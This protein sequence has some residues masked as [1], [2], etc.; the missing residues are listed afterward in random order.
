MD[1]FKELAEKAEQKVLE[2][3]TPSWV[4][5]NNA[6][7]VAY[8]ETERLRCERIMFINKHSRAINFRS[9]KNYQISGREVARAV[10]ISASTLLTTSTYSGEF[11]KY[12]GDINKELEKKK[13]Q[14]IAKVVKSKSRGPIVQSKDELVEKV[15]KLEAKVKYL[16]SKNVIE[17]V[18]QAVNMLHPEIANILVL[19]QTRN[20]ANISHLKPKKK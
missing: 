3:Q 4:N 6:S 13:N 17:Q 11:T 18:E 2:E 5:K 12:L 20:V 10:G 14:R 7:L 15:K 9:K 8:N 19:N 16:E 1:Y